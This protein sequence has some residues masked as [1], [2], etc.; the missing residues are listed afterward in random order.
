MMTTFLDL[1]QSLIDEKKPGFGFKRIA[2][3]M[4]RKCRISIRLLMLWHG[5]FTWRR[6]AIHYGMIS[7][8]GKLGKKFVTNID[9]YVTDQLDY[10]Y[11]LMQNND[12]D[13]VSACAM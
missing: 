11:Y 8:A 13:G 12:G 1:A 2:Q 10:D 5:N 4:T 9:D 6:H 3:C 7:G